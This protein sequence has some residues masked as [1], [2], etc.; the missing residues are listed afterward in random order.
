M[1]RILTSVAVLAVALAAGCGSGS[2]SSGGSAGAPVDGGVLR[3]GIPDN[4]DH[5]DTGI[6]FAV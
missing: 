2:S 5:L 1:R 6:S 4:P 3:G